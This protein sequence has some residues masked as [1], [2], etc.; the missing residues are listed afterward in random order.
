ML[1]A[2]VQ[3]LGSSIKL[4]SLN[5]RA[6]KPGQGAQ[7]LHADTGEAAAVGDFRVCN[8][9][10]LLDDFSAANGATRLV[11]G[12]HLLE[13][14]PSDVLEDTWAPHPEEVIL[15]GSRRQ[16]GHL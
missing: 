2:V 11:P 16:R 5:Y 8:S 15:G 13:K 6:A 7:K 4:S 1:A 12:T 9:I 10:W 3:V 14:L